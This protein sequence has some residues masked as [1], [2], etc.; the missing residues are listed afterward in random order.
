MTYFFACT[1]PG[2]FALAASA[3]IF[4]CAS[5]AA[6]PKPSVPA[7]TSAAKQDA[8]A[9]AKRAES[10]LD[11][12]QGQRGILVEADKL[13][14]DALLRDQQSAHAMVEKGRL[15]I[16]ASYSGG[17]RRDEEGNVAAADMFEKAAKADPNY[18]RAYTL[19]GHVYTSLGRM[20]QAKKALE[21]AEQLGTTDPWL[22]LNWSEY[23]RRSG[24]EAKSVAHCEK[25]LKTGTQKLKALRVAW[26]CINTYY[27]AEHPDRARSDEAYQE[28]M[29]LSP[30]S[31]TIRGDRA[32]ALAV[33]FQDFDAAE[34]LARETIAV[35]DYPHVRGTLSLAL[36]SKWARAIADKKDAAFIKAR[37]IEAQTV[38]RDGSQLPSCAVGSPEFAFLMKELE[39]R[40]AVEKQPLNLRSC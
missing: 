13:I 9:L 28:L 7:A 40:A 4:S 23:W 3:V 20:E 39:K 16:M 2:I 33:Y 34:K 1:R 18:V 27:S 26:S 10:L 5:S 11:Q 31:A 24:N 8:E 35:S 22:N 19:Q 14:V 15:L 12:W 36:Y 37:L 38:D 30:E 25:A 21:H 32:Q 17:G 6:P 29:K